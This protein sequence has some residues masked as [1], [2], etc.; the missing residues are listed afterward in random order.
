VAE[1]VTMPVDPHV[2]WQALPDEQSAIASQPL[3]SSPSQSE[4]PGRHAPIA[5]S[6]AV[7]AASAFAITQLTPHVPQFEASLWRSTHV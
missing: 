4:K 5:H 1:H 6:P 7:H 2:V 3:A